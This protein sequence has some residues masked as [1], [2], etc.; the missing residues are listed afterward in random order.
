MT[1]SLL[2]YDDETGKPAPGVVS[3]G[4]LLR[5]LVMP[6]ERDADPLGRVKLR[7]D[8][9]VRRE[10]LAGTVVRLDWKVLRA[11]SENQKLAKRLWIYLAAE[12]WKRS[13]QN[14]EGTWIACGDRLFAALGMNYAQQ[15]QARAAIKR[16]CET[17]QRVDARY[18]PGELQV[19]KTF[20]AWKIVAKRPRWEAW[21]EARDEHERVRRAVRESLAA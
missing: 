15:R 20:G 3:E 1:L 4:N 18:A 16:A 10:L 6:R 19:I 17:I 2:D 12:R 14:T 5:N 9:W 7:L 8:D 13:G 21:R 11:F